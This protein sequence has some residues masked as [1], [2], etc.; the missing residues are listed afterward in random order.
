MRK[1]GSQIEG[2]IYTL[3]NNSAVKNAIEGSLYRE[4]MRPIN[5]ET[6]DAVVSFLTGLD[7]EIQ[8]GILNLNIYVSDIDSNTHKVK[9]ITRCTELE[10]IANEFIQSL[11]ITGDYKLELDN[12]IQTFK[13]EGIE[14]HFINCRIKF[15]LSTI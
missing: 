5:A 3:I 14:Q 6:E 13:A 7:G 10:S 1:T 4:G 12:M 2:D 15:S 8:T 11:S 9:D